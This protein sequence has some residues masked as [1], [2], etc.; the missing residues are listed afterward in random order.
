MTWKASKG[1]KTPKQQ[2]QHNN[3]PTPENATFETCAI[4]AFSLLSLY[5][6]Q[7]SI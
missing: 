6:S 7:Q 1:R 5:S 2:Q 4:S 3:R